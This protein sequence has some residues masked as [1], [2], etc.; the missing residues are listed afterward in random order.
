VTS[1]FPLPN[2]VL[3]YS[4]GQIKTGA[5]YL[6]YQWYRDLAAVPGATT[7]AITPTMPGNYNV[8]VTD[9]NRCVSKS[10]TYPLS[11]VSV[12]EIG[13]SSAPVIYPNPA[14]EKVFVQYTQPLRITITGMDGRLLI[15][16]AHTNE[17]DISTLASGVYLIAV[18]DTDG[19]RIAV[20]KLV[21]E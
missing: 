2:P 16:A 6:S 15:D 11:S 10:L 5:F 4:G 7:F 8:L 1:V 19:N 13:S 9:T 14:K 3:V 18:Y 20:E 12:K 21:K 17:T